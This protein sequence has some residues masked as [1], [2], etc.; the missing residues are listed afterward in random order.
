[1]PLV[2]SSRTLNKLPFITKKH[3]K[4]PIIPLSRIWCP[5]SF[6]STCNGV[7]AHTFAMIT[8]PAKAHFIYISTLR[9]YC[10]VVLTCSTMCFPERMTTSSKSNCLIII[11]CH[12]AKCFSDIFGTCNWVRIAVRSLRVD[13]DQTHLHCTKGLVKDSVTSVTFVCQ[14]LCFFSPKNIIFWPPY[15]N[16][17][18]SK[19]KGFSSH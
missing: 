13:I 19:S 16:T 18:T 15:V 9:F 11:H 12:S 3:I 1:M 17:A 4:I 10:L 2:C 6:N 8:V 14:P 5:C 7:T